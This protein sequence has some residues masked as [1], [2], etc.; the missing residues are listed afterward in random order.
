MTLFD[1]FC[2]VN[3][4]IGDEIGDGIRDLLEID[5]ELSKNKLI[6]CMDFIVGS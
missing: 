3:F 1:T 2:R 6:K 4:K 5:L